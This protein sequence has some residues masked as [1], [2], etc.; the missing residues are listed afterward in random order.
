[1]SQGDP[2]KVSG[3]QHGESFRIETSGMRYK[4]VSVTLVLHKSVLVFETFLLEVKGTL[5]LSLV[6]TAC[7][8]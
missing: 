1:M 3:G 4:F 2:L 5:P 8:S 6:I 7:A